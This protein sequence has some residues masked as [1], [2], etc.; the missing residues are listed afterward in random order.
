[1]HLNIRSLLQRNKTDHLGVLMS[2]TG[3]G[4][5]I[6]TESWQKESISDGEVAINNH[7]IFRN[8][9]MGGRGG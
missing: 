4:I 6:L 3:P 1:M 2:H 5:L 8:D 7:N 9:R